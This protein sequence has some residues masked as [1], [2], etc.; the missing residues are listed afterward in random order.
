M[1][2]RNIDVDLALNRLNEL[3]FLHRY[4]ECVLF[5]NRLNHVTI[6]PLVTKL[7]ID[8]FLSRLPYT[9]EIFEALYSKLFII[10]PDTFPIRNLQPERLID[11]MI[12][13]FSLLADQSKLEP[14]DGLKILN[15][16]ENV[17]RVISYVQP[18]MYT[19]LLYFK[20]AID[21]SLIRLERDLLHASTSNS[22]IS[23][24]NTS[25]GHRKSTIGSSQSVGGSQ[26]SGFVNINLS[27]R[28]TSLILCEAIKYEVL[29]TIGLCEKASLKLNDYA[30][31]MKTEKLFKD[32][33]YYLNTHNKRSK[34]SSGRF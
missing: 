5:L 28:N 21:N 1:S 13:Y 11:K 33:Q 25:K 12:S 19:R 18:Y 8:I 31:N 29:H 23:S 32:A 27:A 15:S 10:D 3:F 4:D 30:T 7:S 17:I 16:F 20:Y 14:I 24:L 9:I 26:N 34:I 22:F 6:K 2:L